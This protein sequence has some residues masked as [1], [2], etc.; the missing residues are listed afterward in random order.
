MA[1]F[2]AILISL[3]ASVIGAIC[4]IGGGVIIKPAL[5]A[6][7]VFDVSTGNFLSACTVFAMSAYSISR[8]IVLKEINFRGKTIFLVSVGAVLGGLLGKD[9]LNFVLNLTSSENFV[10]WLQSLYLIIL[11]GLT[12]VYTL[13]K[14]RIKTQTINNILM[15]LLVGFFLGYVSSFLGI[16]G[17]PINLMVLSFFFSM[18]TKEASIHSIFIILFS[19]LS[20][21]SLTVVK[22]NVPDKMTA[23]I[24]LMMLCGVAGGIIGRSINKK[25]NAQVVDKLFIMLM[26][27]IVFINTHNLVMFWSNGI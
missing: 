14:N 22:G 26:C 19:Q 3:L 9:F 8:N 10:G 25:I 12:I 6:L 13:S 17:G 15:I 7:S 23:T 5:D 2:I 24:I 20:N 4:G 16:G 27:I 1:F 21:L 11:T 18:D